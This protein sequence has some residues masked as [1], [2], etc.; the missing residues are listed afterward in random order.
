MRRHRIDPAGLLNGITALVQD[1]DG[2]ASGG[3]AE[4]PAGR[5]PA[6]ARHD[7]PELGYERSRSDAKRG[8]ATR[9]RRATSTRTG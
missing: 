9:L 7:L 5:F 8:R 1:F 4:L 2:L 3:Y 6:F